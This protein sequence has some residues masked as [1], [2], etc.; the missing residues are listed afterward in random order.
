MLIS[1]YAVGASRGVLYV[2][3]GFGRAAKIGRAL[4]QMRKYN[5]LGDHIL[6]SSFRCEIEVRE[7]PESVTA[8]DGRAIFHTLHEN[9]IAPYLSPTYPGIGEFRGKA[10]AITNAETMSGVSAWF[11]KGRAS[12]VVTLQGSIAHPYRVEVPPDT[13]IRSLLEGI[14][15][16]EAG[17]QYIRAVLIGGPAGVFLSA[18]SLDLPISYIADEAIGSNAASGFI[19]V[20][21]NGACMVEATKDAMSYIT[22]QSCGKCFFCREGSR[23]IC[24]IL[25][26]ISDRRGKPGDLDLLMELGEE[27]RVAC[28]CSFGKNASNPVLSSIRLF[29]GDYESKLGGVD[30]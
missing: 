2:K 7:V 11:P 8:G 28:L 17:D 24:N 10:V 19:T 30:S 4:E 3:E 15:I 13:S 22:A 23:Q 16:G 12:K 27:M 1:A 5:L 29:R 25:E 14:G 21:D 18:D 9:Q 20:F 6:D 26:D